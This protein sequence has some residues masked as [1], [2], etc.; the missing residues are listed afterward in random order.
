[1]SRQPRR[2]LLPLLL[3]FVV[4]VSSCATTPQSAAL[5]QQTPTKLPEAFV[6]ADLPFF[7]QDDYQCGPA[8]LATVL[9]ASGIAITPELLVP[10]V[11][12]PKRKG[13]FQIE[14]TAAAR[15]QGRLVYTLAP[16]LEALLQEVAAGH[17]ALILQNLGLGMLPRW[18]F[19]VVKGF[20]LARKRLL[21][22]SGRIENYEIS[23]ATFERTWARADYWAQVVLPPDEV[24]VTA[25]ALPFFTAVVALEQTGQPDAAMQAYDAGLQRWP[26]DQH[27]LMGAGNLHYAQGDSYD[28]LVLFTR[29]VE[30]YPD[31]APA[32]NNAAQLHHERGDATQA[33]LH[34]RRAVDIGGEFAEVYRATLEQLE[35]ER[36]GAATQVPTTESSPASTP[37]PTQTPARALN[38]R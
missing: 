37:A 27:L 7:P 16:E 19:A 4:L 17:P 33:L 1:M 38:P 26:E 9:Q 8:A 18:H 2:L 5:L 29:V 6:L 20:D 11:Y 31:F 21:L 35:L 28:A 24:P 25:A 22:N 36:P 34:A 23:L 13:S 15:S 14:M 30:L 32:H 12:V 10:L 3:I